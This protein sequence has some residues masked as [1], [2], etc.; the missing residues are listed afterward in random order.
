TYISHRN[1]TGYKEREAR[2]VWA[3]YKQLADGKPLKD[4][5]RDDGRKLVGY[6]QGQGVKSRTIKKKLMWLTASVNLAIEEG[7]RF[8]P[9][10]GVIPKGDDAERRLAFDESDVK[11]IQR[12]MGRLSESGQLLLRLLA[13]T[14]MRLSE[15]FQIDCEKVEG[16][17]RYVIVGSKTAQSLRRVP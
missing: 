16:K 9:F 3:L 11:V 15:A 12:N 5:S 10:K 1:I 14:G 7:H 17:A 2:H 13:S 6:F 8:N 4:A